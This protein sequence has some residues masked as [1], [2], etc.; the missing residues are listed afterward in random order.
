MK[1]EIIALV[2]LSS[3]TIHCK[4][5]KLYPMCYKW[6]PLGNTL[7]TV[8]LAGVAHQVFRGHRNVVHFT[9]EFLFEME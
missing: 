9:L 8:A 4:K 1:K 3:H 5:G 6:L 2:W 7:W